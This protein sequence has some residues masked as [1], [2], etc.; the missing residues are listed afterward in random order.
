MGTDNCLLND[1][2]GALIETLSMWNAVN[3]SIFLTFQGCSVSQ[4]SENSASDK[5]DIQPA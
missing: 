1:P 2:E 5:D 4:E 3:I